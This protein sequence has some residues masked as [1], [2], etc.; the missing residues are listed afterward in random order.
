VR[1]EKFFLKHLKSQLREGGLPHENKK[2]TIVYG[3]TH[4]GGFGELRLK[5]GGDPLRVYNCGGWVVG[6]KGERPQPQ[7]PTCHF[8][9]VDEEGE[10]YLLDIVFDE[11]AT[12]GEQTL[13]DLAAD[14]AEHRLKMLGHGVRAVGGALAFLRNPFGRWRPFG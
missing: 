6:P 13:L 14:D 2:M 5:D 1:F 4:R 12:V 9:A 8:F 7:H 11:R 10:E 3:D